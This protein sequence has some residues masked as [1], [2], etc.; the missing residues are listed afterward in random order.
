MDPDRRIAPRQPA[1]RAWSQRYP[2][3]GL[4]PIFDRD[5]A[6]GRSQPLGRPDET[7]DDDRRGPILVVDDDE[8][9]LETVCDILEAEGYDVVIAHNGLEALRAIDV[10]HP[11]VVLLDM[12]MPVLDGWGVAQRLRERGPDVPVLVMT[13]A[14]DARRWALEIGAAGYVAKPFDV[15]DL[16]DAVERVGGPPPQDR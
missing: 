10:H 1:L 3:R 9:I 13:A 6:G 4:G 7:G 15:V 8:G 12:R 11:V 2:L 14:Q 16:L 5:E